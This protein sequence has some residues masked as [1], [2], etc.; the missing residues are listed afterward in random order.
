[1]YFWL[2]SESKILEN[3]CNKIYEFYTVYLVNKVL[4]IVKYLNNLN[5]HL[6]D[7]T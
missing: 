2:H 6:I 5:K 7:I 4:L 3:L 1:M